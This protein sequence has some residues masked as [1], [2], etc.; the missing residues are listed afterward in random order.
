MK[1]ATPITALN[2]LDA[3]SAL[4]QQWRNQ[5]TGRRTETPLELRTQALALLES[6]PRSHVV[7]ALGINHTMLKQWQMS[8]TPADSASAFLPVS[9]P[10]ALPQATRELTL[11]FGNGSQATLRG[12]FSLTELT[13]LLRGLSVGT[14]GAA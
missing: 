14:E 7:K 8:T 4:F 3:V 9:L 6:H 10:T 5:H 2:K 1:H 11:V 12:D 13:T